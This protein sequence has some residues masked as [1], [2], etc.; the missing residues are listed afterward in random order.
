M[1]SLMNRFAL[2]KD[3]AQ[4]KA[5]PEGAAEGRHILAKIWINFGTE[6]VRFPT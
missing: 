2:G 1:F 5:A 4:K 6:C 3:F